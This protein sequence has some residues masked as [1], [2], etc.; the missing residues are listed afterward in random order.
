M[1][2]RGEK[3]TIHSAAARHEAYRILF[4][5]SVQARKELVY[6][7]NLMVSHIRKNIKKLYGIKVAQAAIIPLGTPAKDYPVPPAGISTQSNDNKK[8]IR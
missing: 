8:I 1:G 2:H 3:E 4:P 7:R 5:K 6:G